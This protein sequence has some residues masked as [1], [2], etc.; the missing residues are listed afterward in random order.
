[1]DEYLNATELC[2]CDNAELQ[3]K[4]KEII[5]D[6]KTPKEA[7]LKIFYF[8]RDEIPWML[9][10][11]DV[12]A[13]RTLK[14]GKGMCC[15]KANLQVALLRAVSIPA[16]YHQSKVKR[17]WLKGIISSFI[18]SRLPEV[19]EYSPHCECYL[20]KKWVAC[21]SL[22]DKAL[23]EAMFREGL[24][25]KEQIPTIDWDG[26]KELV[27]MTPWITES[28]GTFSSMDDVFRKAEKETKRPRVLVQ[29]FGWFF[30]SRSN[31]RTDALLKGK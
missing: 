13:S 6:T 9:D 4:A 14:K 19:V 16:R 2:D 23:Y 21:D 28:V 15:N 31:Q 29:L 11:W 25:T 7:A 10:A 20:S 27:V 1:M 3:G 26:E 22:L 12:K 5:K 30:M 18:Y 24:V 8:V 17:E